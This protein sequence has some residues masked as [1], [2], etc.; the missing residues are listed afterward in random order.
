MIRTQDG[1]A[2]YLEKDD[3]TKIPRHAVKDLP[4]AGSI[5]TKQGNP[6][7]QSFRAQSAKGT[8]ARLV[9]IGA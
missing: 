6:C 5:P 9:V 2:S 7:E 1:C 4:I 8:F 3:I